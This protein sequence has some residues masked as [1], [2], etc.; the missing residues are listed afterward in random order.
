[1]ARSMIENPN[2]LVSSKSPV[3]PKNGTTWGQMNNLNKSAIVER[4]GDGV[5]NTSMVSGMSLPSKLQK[6]KERVKRD[7]SQNA[8]N[9]ENRDNSLYGRRKVTENLDNEVQKLRESYNMHRKTG[10]KDNRS[11]SG[12][13][14]S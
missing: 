14:S 12:L 7:R 11:V 13:R 4:H 3:R 10:N 6:M 1:M 2:S 5:T 8:I 9:D